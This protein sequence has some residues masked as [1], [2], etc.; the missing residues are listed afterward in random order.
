LEESVD[1]LA[2]AFHLSNFNL[3]V[4]DVEFLEFPVH[5][6]LG[7]L[8]QFYDFGVKLLQLKVKLNSKIFLHLT[9]HQHIIAPIP[10]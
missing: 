6:L 4:L 10:L 2:F 1:V 8:F 9:A 5:N 3:L 7:C